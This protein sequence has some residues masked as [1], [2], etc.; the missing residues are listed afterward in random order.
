MTEERKREEER[1]EEEKKELAQKK[2]KWIIISASVVFAGILAS[3]LL[4]VLSTQ[5]TIVRHGIISGIILYLV[6]GV[7]ARDLAERLDRREK[8][9]RRVAAVKAKLGLGSKTA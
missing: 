5:K 7:G 8:R 9:R 6:Y 3:V 1:I 4:A 2:R